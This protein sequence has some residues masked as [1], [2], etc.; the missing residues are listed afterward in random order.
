MIKLVRHIQL[1]KISY[2]PSLFRAVITYEPYSN[3]FDESDEI[4]YNKQKSLMNNMVKESYFNL[5]YKKDM[6]INNKKYSEDN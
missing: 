2:A 4:E 5:Y 3:K 1:N 6:E